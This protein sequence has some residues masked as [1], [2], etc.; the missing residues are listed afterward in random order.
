[1]FRVG[2]LFLAGV[3]LWLTH[4]RWDSPELLR[5]QL[6]SQWHCPPW[7]KTPFLRW[8]LVPTSKTPEMVR[9]GLAAWL[10]AGG[11]GKIMD[12]SSPRTFIPTGISGQEY[13]SLHLWS[14]LEDPQS[15]YTFSGR[16]HVSTANNSLSRHLP[17]S[18]SLS[19]GTA[20]PQHALEVKCSLRG[21]W[22]NWDS[23]M[24]WRHSGPGL[25]TYMPTYTGLCCFWLCLCCTFL[26]SSF[27]IIILC[28][29]Q[30]HWHSD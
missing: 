6:R 15:N 25:N 14:R 24:S 2:K 16:K 7:K 18:T 27:S 5:Y 19:L 17:L 29:K 12:V 9:D 10:P 26:S 13:F 1:M 4:S 3:L 20:E 21:L 30:W 28:C 23:L 8:Q 22:L 11:W